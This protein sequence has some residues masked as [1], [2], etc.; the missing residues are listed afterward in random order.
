[1]IERPKSSIGL[2]LEGKNPQ[3]YVIDICQQPRGLITGSLGTKQ[4]LPND[5]TSKNNSTYTG[6][7]CSE[8]L[9]DG[10]LKGVR[11]SY[12]QETSSN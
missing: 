12:T 1:M 10:V 11:Q 6:A 3:N 7:T 8:R 5:H 9:E 2:S 4:L